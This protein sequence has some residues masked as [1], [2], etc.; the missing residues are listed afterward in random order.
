M[1]NILNAIAKLGFTEP[2]P[3]QA[4]GWPMALKG[5]EHVSLTKRRFMSKNIEPIPFGKMQ[6]VPFNGKL[7][8]AKKR[9]HWCGTKGFEDLPQIRTKHPKKKRMLISSSY[10]FHLS[11]STLQIHPTLSQGQHFKHSYTLFVKTRP[12]ISTPSLCPSGTAPLLLNCATAAKSAS[13]HPIK[14]NYTR[15]KYANPNFS[16]PNTTKKKSTCRSSDNAKLFRNTFYLLYTP[17]G[18][19]AMVF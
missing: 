11:F 6:V 17:N 12:Q 19:Y 3:I 4:Q 18:V 1:D 16:C 8:K 15:C 10:C 7:V 2:T 13:Y 14:C 5:E 9:C